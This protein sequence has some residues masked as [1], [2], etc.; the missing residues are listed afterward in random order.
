MIGGLNACCKK[1]QVVPVMRII[2]PNLQ[3]EKV[4]LVIRTS[5]GNLNA[6]IDTNYIDMSFNQ[7]GDLTAWIHLDY[8]TNDYIIKIDSS[9]HCDTI[10]DIS[11]RTK[12]SGCSYKILDFQYKHN[13]V[14]KS[15]TDLTIY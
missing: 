1:K 13:S 3:E 4:A 6:V 7:D 8:E 10:T 11:Y 2:Y 14:L 5:Q 12:G 15:G 9:S